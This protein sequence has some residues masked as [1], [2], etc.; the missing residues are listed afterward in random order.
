[1]RFDRGLADRTRPA[2]F[3]RRALSRDAEGGGM[4]GP[5]R[6][7]GTLR[8][9]GVGHTAAARGRRRGGH[10]AAPRVGRAE[11]AARV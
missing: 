5:G 3:D 8:P 4:L 9:P 11:E 7:G 2:S 6:P 1:M 10:A